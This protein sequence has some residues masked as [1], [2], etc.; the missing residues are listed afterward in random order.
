MSKREKYAKGIE[1]LEK[2]LSLVVADY[3]V[4]QGYAKKIAARH[5][6]EIARSI[7]ALGGETPDP[8]PDGSGGGP[9]FPEPPPPNPN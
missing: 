9:G 3:F 8:P 2:E 1:A 7:V 6:R 5:W 4:S